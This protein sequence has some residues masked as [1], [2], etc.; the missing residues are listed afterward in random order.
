MGRIRLM[1]YAEK[2]ILC[3]TRRNTRRNYVNAM[4]IGGVGMNLQRNKK[5]KLNDLA[6]KRIIEHLDYISGGNNQLDFDSFQFLK[7]NIS[8]MTFCKWGLKETIKPI[9][10]SIEIAIALSI[11]IYIY[12]CFAGFQVAIILLTG[13]IPIQIIGLMLILMTAYKK[14]V[15]ESFVIY[16]EIIHSKMIKI[17]EGDFNLEDIKKNN[18]I[19][20]SLDH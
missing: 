2:Q 10:G 19:L 13:A 11:A 15:E 18:E 7:D 9:Q 17:S 5:S 1:Q 8:F 12:A 3:D 6:N 16:F 4:Q 14:G 20:N